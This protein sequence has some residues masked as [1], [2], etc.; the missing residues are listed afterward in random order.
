M[1]LHYWW[2]E[3]LDA[4]RKKNADTTADAQGVTERDLAQTT[5]KYLEEIAER[6]D[7]WEMT[8]AYAILSVICFSTALEANLHR[9]FDALK[10]H[11][12]KTPDF[13]A[14]SPLPDVSIATL[15][16]RLYTDDDERAWEDIF[17]ETRKFAGVL[18]DVLLRLQLAHYYIAELRKS[19]GSL[20]SEQ[21]DKQSATVN[22]T[23]G[24]AGP[25]SAEG[26]YSGS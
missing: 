18:G 1:G 6:L 9:D 8:I 12:D 22:D 19:F 15:G 26:G 24:D 7:D 21:L 2:Q 14:F 4:M 20:F 23:A 5:E 17:K 10:K 11:E 3:W 16:L 25:L 13:V